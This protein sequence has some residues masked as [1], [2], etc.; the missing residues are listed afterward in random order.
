MDFI[1]HI[2]ISFTS[3]RSNVFR[4]FFST[5]GIIIG[6]MAVVALLGI[7]KSAQRSIELSF[8]SFGSNSIYVVPGQQS[9]NFGP[10]NLADTFTLSEVDRFIDYPKKYIEGIAAQTFTNFRVQ[11]GNTTESQTILG[12]H[13]DYI[14]IQN[15]EAEYG[16]LL[17]KKDS[18]QRA[19]VALVGPDLIEDFFNGENPVGKTMRINGTSFTVIGVFKKK[20]TSSFDNPND[21]IMIPFTTYSQY[22]VSGDN[23]SLVSVE[24]IDPKFVEQ[25]KDETRSILRKIR[26]VGTNQE[27]DFTV[28]DSGEILSS[29][30]QIT[31]IFTGFLSSIAAISLLVGGIGVTNIMFV[32]ITERTKEIGLRKSIGAKNRD[33]LIQFL[34]E[35]IMVTLLGGIIGICVGI[36][37]S[38]IASKL[39]D[40]PTEIYLDA[41]GLGVLFSVIIG[42]IFGI[43]PAQ[44]ASKLNPIDALRYE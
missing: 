4:T 15:F 9:D 36:I 14:E 43:Y 5:L 11:Y 21:D 41:I 32:S 44:K 35:S 24:A 7:G 40:L 25:A 42:L 12:S 17:T 20:G 13:G 30:N 3:L 8:D 16:R 2:T 18:D 39:L 22:L 23:L 37:L 1:D 19:K 28:R 26:G 27:D 34:T 38:F 33:I 6:V 29:I 31:G 10:P